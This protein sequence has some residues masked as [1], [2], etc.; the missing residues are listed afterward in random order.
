MNKCFIRHKV[1]LRIIAIGVVCLFLVNDLSFAAEG[2]RVSKNTGTL[3]P[4]SRIKPIVTV[5]ERSG[6]TIVVENA[7]ERKRLTNAFQEDAGFI[8]LNTLITQVLQKFGSRM[9]A[10]GLKDLIGKHLSH[11]DSTRFKWKEVYKEGD[12][13]CLPYERKDDG[14]TQILRYYPSGGKPVEFPHQVDL[15]LDDGSTAILEDPMREEREKLPA[16]LARS[17]MTAEH[18]AAQGILSAKELVERGIEV[19]ASADDKDPSREP[20]ISCNMIIPESPEKNKRYIDKALYEI[21]LGSL[22]V[23]M[24]RRND[25]EDGIIELPGEKLKRLLG[26]RARHS[27]IV[28][29]DPSKLHPENRENVDY[30]S[31][32]FSGCVEMRFS[33]AVTPEAFKAVI[34][35]AGLATVIGKAF[36][37]HVQ[38]IETPR[39]IDKEIT[40]SRSA[41]LYPEHPDRGTMAK[42]RTIKIEIPDYEA[43][44]NECLNGMPEGNKLLTHIVRLTAPSDVKGGTRQEKTPAI[45]AELKFC[46]YSELPEALKTEALYDLIDD[47]NA[48][49]RNPETLIFTRSYMHMEIARNLKLKKRILDKLW[50]RRSG[51][52]IPDLMIAFNGENKP[53]GI[54]SFVMSD[55]EE[56]RICWANGIFVGEDFREEGI[57]RVLREVLLDYLKNKGYEEFMIGDTD[58]DFPGVSPDDAAQNLTGALIKEHPDAVK[59]VTETPEG[60][61]STLTMDL[62]KFHAEHKYAKGYEAPD[63]PR[64]GGSTTL[65]SVAGP[66]LSAMVI[67]G[68]RHGMYDAG[69]FIDEL[70]IIFTGALILTVP[71]LI[72][73]AGRIMLGMILLLDP[74][75]RATVAALSGGVIGAIGAKLCFG[76][77]LPSAAAYV[78]GPLL[79]SAG[80]CLI[81]IGVYELGRISIGKL[82]KD[83]ITPDE[84]DGPSA[85]QKG[86]F[87]MFVMGNSGLA[88]SFESLDLTDAELLVP[89]VAIAAPIA[90]IYALFNPRARASRLVKKFDDKAPIVRMEALDRI[91]TF[92]KDAIPPLVEALKSDNITVQ[93]SAATALGN[94]AGNKP[95]LKARIREDAGGRLRYLRSRSRGEQL[96]RAIDRLF[97]IIGRSA[98]D[99]PNLG[100]PNSYDLASH[101]ILRGH[102]KGAGQFQVWGEPVEGLVQSDYY[103]QRL[104]EAGIDLPKDMNLILIQPEHGQQHSIERKFLYFEPTAERWIFS[105][106]GTR[107]GSGK[108]VYM[109]EGAFHFLTHNTRAFAGRKEFLEKLLF[110]EYEH[111][112]AKLEGRWKEDLH[113]RRDRKPRK[114]VEDK[115]QLP[116]LRMTGP[117]ADAILEYWK[118]A[119][120]LINLAIEFDLEGNIPDDLLAEI[121]KQA[122]NA[123]ELRTMAGIMQDDIKSPG[124][125][126][127]NVLKDIVIF[128][129]YNLAEARQLTALMNRLKKEPAV[130]GKKDDFRNF[131]EWFDDGIKR[132]ELFLLIYDD[133]ADTSPEVDVA[134]IVGETVEFLRSLKGFRDIEFDFRINKPGSKIMGDAYATRWDIIAEIMD[135]YSS[136]PGGKGRIFVNCKVLDAWGVEFVADNADER[137]G[138]IEKIR[139][140][141]KN[142]EE[143]FYKELR[144]E[145]KQDRGACFGAS[146]VLARVLSARLDL[147][148]DG[149]SPDRI[150]VEVGEKS[151]GSIIPGFSATHAWVAI[152]R[153]GL[154]VLQV[155]PARGQYDPGWFN[156]M[157]VGGYADALRELDMRSPEELR[158]TGEDRTIYDIL[159]IGTERARLDKMAERVMKAARPGKE[160]KEES[161]GIEAAG[162][163]PECD[164]DAG[165]R[166]ENIVPVIIKTLGGSLANLKWREKG[167][168]KTAEVPVKDLDEKEIRIAFDIPFYAELKG[169]MTIVASGD[170]PVLLYL[171][172]GEGRMKMIDLS[173]YL[174]G[175]DPDIAQQ[176]ARKTVDESGVVNV[177][178]AINHHIYV[179]FNNWGGIVEIKYM[180]P[181]PKDYRIPVKIMKVPVLP[182]VFAG[183]HSS[184]LISARATAKLAKPGMKVL[185]IGPGA[186]VEARIAAELGANV[187]AVDIQKFAVENTKITC[188]PV[189][190]QGRVNAFVNDLFEGLGRYDLIIFNMPHVGEKMPKDAPARPSDVN[191]LDPGAKLLKR[192]A[193]GIAGHI[194]RGGHAVLVNTEFY[195]V[196]KI[197]EEMTGLKVHTDFFNAPGT[198]MSQAYIISKGPGTEREKP[199]SL[200]AQLEG[201]IHQSG[202]SYKKGVYHIDAAGEKL[203]IDLLEMGAAYRSIEVYNEKEEKIA[204]LYAYQ[205]GDDGTEAEGMLGIRG[206]EIAPAYRRKGLSVRMMETFL[207]EYGSIDILHGSV[208][209]PVLIHIAQKHFAFHP[210]APS[211]GNAGYVSGAKEDGARARIW[212]PDK[213]A[214]FFYSMGPREAMREDFEI[215]QEEPPD[216]GD[217]VKIYFNTVYKRASSAKNGSGI[218]AKARGGRRLSPAELEGVDAVIA[219]FDGVDRDHSIGVVHDDTIEAK[220]ALSRRGVHNITITGLDEKMFFERF[221]GQKRAGRITSGTP[222]HVLTCTGAVGNA[223]EK[224]GYLSPINGFEMA[225]LGDKNAKAKIKDIAREAMRAAALE[226]GIE[227]EAAEE[228]KS[229]IKEEQVTLFTRKDERINSIRHRIAELI[230]DSL[231]KEGFGENIEVACSAGAV[232]ITATSKKKAA[233]QMISLLHL[234][235]V[236]L[237]GDSAGTEKRPGNDRSLLTLTQE[238][239]AEAGIDRDVELIPVYVG[240]ETGHELPGN[241]VI[242]EQGEKE[243][244]PA[245]DLY[246]AVI[247]EK[248]NAI[249]RG[250]EKG[251][252]EKVWGRIDRRMLTRW[253]QEW[254]NVYGAKGAIEIPPLYRS[255][256]DRTLT[257]RIGEH[258]CS[259]TFDVI[260]DLATGRIRL[261]LIGLNVDEKTTRK[262][263]MSLVVLY[264][265]H[266]YGCDEAYHYRMSEE[267]GVKFFEG[268]KKLGLYEDTYSFGE[269]EGKA[270]HIHGFSGINRAFVDGAAKDISGIRSF[271]ERADDSRGW[272]GLPNEEY[273]PELRQA[274]DS[275]DIFAV[276]YDGQ[277]AVPAETFFHEARGEIPLG[278]IEHRGPGLRYINKAI[279]KLCYQDKRLLENVSIVF[280]EGEKDA[281]YSLSRDRIYINLR[282]QDNT[283]GLKRLLHH[284]LAERSHVIGKMDAF[285]PSWRRKRG[286]EG[287]EDQIR[288]FAAEK[289]EVLKRNEESTVLK[290][291][292]E[293]L[294]TEKHPVL[295][296]RSFTELMQ[297]AFRDKHEIRGFDLGTATGEKAQ[298]VKE[299]LSKHVR[300]VDFVGVEKDDRKVEIALKYGYPVV[301][302]DAIDLSGSG[303]EKGSMDL[304]TSFSPHPLSIKGFVGTAKYLVNE[305]GMAV[306]SLAGLDMIDLIMGERV[307]HKIDAE[308]VWEALSDFHLVKFTETDDW[309]QAVSPNNP[310]AFVYTPQ[311][312]KAE[313]PLSEEAKRV[314]PP[315]SGTSSGEYAE[316]LGENILDDPRKHNIRKAG[317]EDIDAVEELSRRINSA[318]NGIEAVA[319]IEESVNAGGPGRVYVYEENG[320]VKGYIWFE[321]YMN[322]TSMKIEEIAVKKE[323]EGGG[324]APL[325]LG[326]IMEGGIELGVDR[327]ETD[328]KITAERSFDLLRKFSFSQ[329]QGGPKRTNALRYHLELEKGTCRWRFEMPE[330]SQDPYDAISREIDTVMDGMKGELQGAEL[331]VIKDVIYELALNILDHAESGHIDVYVMKV[332]GAG[333]PTL[334]V[335]SRSKGK[336][337]PYSPNELMEASLYRRDTVSRGFGFPRIVKDPDRVVIEYDGDKW[338]RKAADKFTVER[339]KGSIA[340]GVR[341]TL[342]FNVSLKND[343]RE[344]VSDA[345][346]FADTVMARAFEA[347]K[348]GENIIIG[349]DMSWIADMQGVQALVNRISRITKDK[350]LDNV[351]VVRGRGI[352]LAGN[353]I[354]EA[355]KTGISLSNVIVLGE[356]SVIRDKA[357]D[358]LRSTNTEKKAFLAGVDARNLGEDS[359]ISLLE[360]LTLAIKLA[361][362]DIDS[363]DDPDMIAVKAGPRTWIFIPRARP[364]SFEEKKAVYEAQ[365]QALIAA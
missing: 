105:H 28:I 179:V 299:L 306:I 219:D 189:K 195:P 183:V 318:G 156:R 123:R 11:V 237:M 290:V 314:I 89:G 207:S 94:I 159:K 18:V 33:R 354:R 180:P 323:D 135:I 249:I 293:H 230:R 326:T 165:I 280:F 313:H 99:T 330:D 21:Y 304:V 16:H 332:P 324:I 185:V 24:E 257:I 339:G 328:I 232:D 10:E 217:F 58:N 234:R 364:M 206:I 131:F 282:Y 229:M 349:L 100:S 4:V 291:A 310:Y 106:S 65:L 6:Q 93:T 177:A 138:F 256:G 275:G 81:A 226:A 114:Y 296:V 5:E 340:S 168:F 140:E 338:T 50:G 277:K 158:A 174:P 269:K 155:D 359:Y 119:G 227:A 321:R 210:V 315:F 363:I 39:M 333:T 246:N 3:S 60:K 345:Q 285:D 196:N 344:R 151:R 258:R 184:S 67:A 247:E 77:F 64:S 12:V 126:R 273:T 248:N 201:D 351:I 125:L 214:R 268:L 163:T 262:R 115:F 212:I 341:I 252:T 342:D 27:F 68:H 161:D 144:K 242:A 334:R 250:Y 97:N 255:D 31:E 74:V 103:K 98:P 120:A 133:E 112:T 346:E 49:F 311:V 270:A 352:D 298:E 110:D 337:L 243:T 7:G 274:I 9:S 322:S 107:Q 59:S 215:L 71:I 221:E 108:F 29:I 170:T 254:K 95:K 142:L 260:K 303:F 70:G 335:V 51:G 307:Y 350:G 47:M 45:Q 8:Y 355:E 238:D 157:Y 154:K 136:M 62:A 91:S 358:A 302:A 220:Q 223:V 218:D 130:S 267:D 90:V 295:E 162:K 240:R 36:P 48:A 276:E 353:V 73:H 281:H 122:T 30:M 79:C 143:P 236:I 88:G 325:L 87:P 231:R 75:K 203:R 320:E 209:N 194:T 316:W 34:V 78:V 37:P 300:R 266:L 32:S 139:T 66:I 278:N 52:K 356:E 102:L 319:R 26:E 17:L 178:G 84:K 259:V 181:D 233:I 171:D 193:E 124:Y 43:V 118:T 365:A 228:I 271:L 117:V 175:I 312:K 287:I 241:V 187:D 54:Y 61:I 113:G 153:N 57:G 343:F 69:S 129:R 244:S 172:G 85:T 272:E 308:E 109:T 182:G 199:D 72:Y 289:H 83:R 265:T 23:A 225:T 169:A 327:F 261:N 46:P 216:L 361:F 348:R 35:P 279:G 176:A 263:L 197:L 22:Q 116:P 137:N 360:M 222:Y 283:R 305:D 128:A 190:A 14:R 150:E 297:T 132:M 19:S 1:F 186:G 166:E 56:G 200:A 76:T 82:L 92:G 245:L 2:F 96:N 164:S 41:P 55:P 317:L 104:S 101:E 284:E 167:D 145:H 251:R 141:C 86:L 173:V 121:Q 211:E 198:A 20:R 202:G 191:T 235:K 44:L 42:E 331:G 188:S 329:A 40:V 362:G 301:Q 53:V 204:F 15:K 292:A 336:G 63:T 13:F 253:L 146:Y 239:L 152:Y 149:D 80:A 309:P 25:E 134:S 286:Q 224:S 192:V 147:P 127:E 148:I 357:F 347:A 208:M 213:S 111:A 38:V 288:T 264:L 160:G 205:G 294:D